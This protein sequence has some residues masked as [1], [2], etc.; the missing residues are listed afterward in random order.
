MIADMYYP[1]LC[2]QQLGRKNKKRHESA[3]SVDLLNNA[4]EPSSVTSH[5]SPFNYLVE[6]ARGAVGLGTARSR[7]S[8]NDS[9][10]TVGSSSSSNGGISSSPSNRSL[11]GASGQSDI[12]TSSNSKSGLSSSVSM[13]DLSVN[14]ALFKRGNT[15]S[16]PSRPVWLSTSSE[17]TIRS[18]S[19][20]KTSPSFPGLSAE[21][22]ETQSPQLS[23][24]QGVS[25]SHATLLTII[26]HSRRR[27]HIRS[28]PWVHAKRSLARLT[29]C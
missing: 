17:S 1:T 20:L 15:A 26:T 24:T 16:T 12:D 6:R 18:A 2:V 29:I 23:A 8:S 28:R 27:L 22:T 11:F 3:A 25:L 14:K 7:T 9:Q 13:Q 5:R 10:L 4:S 21:V 19:P